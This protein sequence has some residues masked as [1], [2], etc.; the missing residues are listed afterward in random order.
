MGVFVDKNPIKREFKTSKF[1]FIFG[2]NKNICHMKIK[3]LTSGISVCFTCSP[4][5]IC[6]IIKRNESDVL[7]IGFEIMT[8]TT[9]KFFCFTL[10]R[11]LP[12][13]S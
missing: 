1:R 5:Y 11:A 7:D 12:N 10:F 13:S 6:D 2:K 8:K 9:F 4:G 3:T